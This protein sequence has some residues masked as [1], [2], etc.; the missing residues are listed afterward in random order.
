M[1]E[2]EIL[3]MSNQPLTMTTP[4]S[5]R[6]LTVSPASV[7]EKIGHTPLMEV[8][9]LDT[10][11]CRLFLK[12]EDRNPGGSI[13][14]RVA[15]SMIEAAERDGRLRPGGT[16]VEATA[17]NTGLGLALVGVAKGYRVALVIP[18]KM[19]PEKVLHLR[20]LGAE[21]TWTRS[22]VSKGHPAYYQDLAARLAAATPGAFY[23]DQFN[24]PAN[25]LAHETTTG[26]EIWEQMNGEVDAVVVGVGSGGT[27]SGLGRFFKRHNPDIEM[28]LS[29][30][31]GSVLAE[32]VRTGSIG[33]AGAWAVEGIGE[34]FVPANAEM[35]LVSEAFTVSDRESFDA[36]R[37]L[38][39]T[40]GV[41]AGSSSGALLA[42][43]LRYC[44]RQTRPKRVVTLVCD[45]GAKYLSRMFN[46]FWMS[47]QGFLQRQ[48]A[49]DLRDLVARRHDAGEVVSV[50]PD[51]PLTVAFKRMRGA[52]VSQ[53]PVLSGGRLVG[54]LDED[55]LLARLG[56]A[57]GNFNT[58][59]SSAMA[60]NLETIAPDKSLA[61]LAAVFDRGHIAIVEEQEQFYGLITRSDLLAY[62]YRLQD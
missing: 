6:P 60:R 31:A 50:A 14:D 47:E 35:S 32:Y 33:A 29:D 17:G 18:D 19:S 36:A 9:R 2:N 20:A 51:D 62:L 53:L 4:P 34:D 56:A 5:D 41:L 28:V 46:D 49:G 37:L 39:K 7:L 52:E 21:V 27:L 61:E 30:P 42:A 13:K 16:I 1:C 54:L 38:L 57:P 59:V 43:A 25:P 26:P 15:L 48:R 11:L 23:I 3:L 24:N 40:E 8:T 10:G 22:D 55:D 45:S 12:L 58:P 44:R